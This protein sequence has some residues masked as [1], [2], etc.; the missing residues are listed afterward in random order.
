MR[1]TLIS[2]LLLLCATSCGGESCDMPEAEYLDR[3]AIGYALGEE[4]ID[5]ITA[6]RELDGECAAHAMADG[7][8]DARADSGE[9][10]D[11]SP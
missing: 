10:C 1:P 9:D 11:Q 4:C 6:W 2:L 5:W 8:N 7:Y 3:Y